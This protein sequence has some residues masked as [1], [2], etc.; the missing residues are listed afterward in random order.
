MS[1]SAKFVK[2]YGNVQVYLEITIIIIFLFINVAQYY[3]I[4]S[5]IRTEYKNLSNLR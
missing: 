3:I 2:R 4:V 1:L 5:N